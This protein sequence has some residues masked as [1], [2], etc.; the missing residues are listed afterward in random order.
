[1]CEIAMGVVITAQALAMGQFWLC[2]QFQETCL[3]FLSSGT[4]SNRRTVKLDPS[5]KSRH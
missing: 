2:F 4:P 5:S 3:P 1:M